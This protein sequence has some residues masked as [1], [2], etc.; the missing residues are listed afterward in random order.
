MIHP[1]NAGFNKLRKKSL[2]FFTAIQRKISCSSSFK[3]LAYV[4]LYHAFF[5]LRRTFV[6]YRVTDFFSNIMHLLFNNKSFL[7]LPSALLSNP[8]NERKK[9]KTL[10]K[11]DFSSYFVRFYFCRTI[12]VLASGKKIQKTILII[13]CHNISDLLSRNCRFIN[14][15]SNE[16]LWRDTGNA[17]V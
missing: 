11:T 16:I 14:E 4:L 10:Q 17:R 13:K 9:K 6:I 15:V 2:K 3:T 5:I 12:P 7:H 8:S 1:K